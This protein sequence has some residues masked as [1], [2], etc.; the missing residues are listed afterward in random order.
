MK[1]LIKNKLKACYNGSEQAILNKYVLAPA[2]EGSPS[3]TMLRLAL[4]RRHS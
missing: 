4:P 3:L 1:E 2:R